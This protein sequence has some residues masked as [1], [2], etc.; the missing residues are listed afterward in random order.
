MFLVIASFLSRKSRKAKTATREQEEFV[1]LGCKMNAL[2]EK[3]VQVW[4]R[5]A[6]ADMVVPRG[7]QMNKVPLKASS[8]SMS[9]FPWKSFCMMCNLN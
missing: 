3:P 8:C 4:R 7:K 6:A 9:V 1:Y 2:T 5:L